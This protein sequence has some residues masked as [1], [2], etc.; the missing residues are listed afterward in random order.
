MLYFLYVYIYIY[1]TVRDFVYL[2]ASKLSMPLIL[3]GL[4]DNMDM[5]IGLDWDVSREVATFV[6]LFPTDKSFGL[7]SVIGEEG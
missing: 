7:E 6:A 4:F 2:R 3:E 5:S 1:I